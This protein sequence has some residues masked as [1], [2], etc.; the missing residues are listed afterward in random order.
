MR[1]RLCED[2]RIDAGLLPQQRRRRE[3]SATVPADGCTGDAEAGDQDEPDATCDAA[4][5]VKMTAEAARAVEE[6][7][8]R[9]PLRRGTGKPR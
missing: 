6:Q 5:T 8:S 4:P 3:T 1:D 9:S 7:V 2:R